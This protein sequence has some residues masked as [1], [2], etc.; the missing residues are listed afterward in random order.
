MKRMLRIVA[1]G[2][3]AISFVSACSS[4]G[5]PKPGTGYRTLDAVVTDRRTE[6]GSLG[7]LTYYLGFEAKDG[8]ATAHMEF[9]VTRDQYLRFPEGT[10][11][12]ISLADNELREIR[13]EAD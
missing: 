2:A 13:K 1:V 7:Q 10:H 12:K 11:V 6:T 3:L 8:E 9:P 5:G 4:S